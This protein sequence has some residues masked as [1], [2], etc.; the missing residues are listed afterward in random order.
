MGGGWFNEAKMTSYDLGAEVRG[1]GSGL[2]GL[3]DAKVTLHKWRGW[4]SGWGRGEGCGIFDNVI[5]ERSLITI[6]TIGQK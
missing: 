4:E 5:S 2:G 6:A 1:G 3:V